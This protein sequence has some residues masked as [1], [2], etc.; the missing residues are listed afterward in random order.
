M[1]TARVPL[2]RGAWELRCEGPVSPTAPTPA[3]ARERLQGALGALPRLDS[4]RGVDGWTV[5]WSGTV[6]EAG[7]RVKVW[8]WL[9]RSD[10]GG[11]LKADLA[12]HLEAAGFA[13]RRG[14]R[15]VV[16]DAAL[17]PRVAYLRTGAHG[18]GLEPR[19]APLF[20]EL[21]VAEEDRD[22]VDIGRVY[23]FGAQPC[24]AC[25][26]VDHPAAL[27]AGFPSPDLMLAA[28]LGEVAFADG[29][30][31]DRRRRRNARCRRCGADF[32]AR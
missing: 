24:P 28:E 21:D 31:V 9:A 1:R 17:E 20:G 2:P 12:A 7:A 13:V 23:R 11:D 15:P 27:V 14:P 6:L 19:T 26:A 8:L 30:L 3:A 10:G 29:G 4:A 5:L 32:V 22:D 16:A 25:G 18:F